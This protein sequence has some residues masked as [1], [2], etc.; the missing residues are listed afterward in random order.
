M[1]ILTKGQKISRAL[2]ERWK[3]PIY[4][5]RWIDSQ[6]YSSAERNSK[7]SN[8]LK[9]R[10]P[11]TA[12]EPKSVAHREKIA[13]AMAKR[14]KQWPKPTTYLERAL[15]RLMKEIGFC[16]VP[17]KRFGRYIVDVYVPDLELAFEADGS[18]WHRDLERQDNRDSYL[19]E[20]GVIEIIHLDET[21]LQ[22]WA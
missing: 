10:A 22:P 8:T 12:R 17:E 7:I 3:D 4:R 14:A 13:L 16:F 2:K 18:F 21:D 20:R 9:A 5:A 11:I 19:R 15:Y 6:D 1:T